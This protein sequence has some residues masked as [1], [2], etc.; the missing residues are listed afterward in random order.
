RFSPD[1]IL[2]FGNREQIALF[3][4]VGKEWRM[5]I[6]FT[7]VKQIANADS[8]DLISM[9]IRAYSLVIQEN[10]H[11]PI[12]Q[13]RREHLIED[14]HSNTRFAA[15]GGNPAVAGIEVVVCLSPVCQ[16]VVPAIIV[17]NARPQ[18]LVAF[19]SAERL[20]PLV[21][22]RRH[23]LLGKLASYPVGLLC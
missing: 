19:V 9:D 16:R 2:G 4:S 21:L 7:A 22:V 3:R 23:G 6:F 13:K 15:D 14:R 1:G 18:F 11:L 5:E 8:R 17:A 10:L 20:N 12:S